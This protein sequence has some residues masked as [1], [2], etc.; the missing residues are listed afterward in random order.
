MHSKLVVLSGALFCAAGSF[1]NVV[2]T[3][4]NAE[5]LIAPDACPVVRFAADDLTNHLAMVFG[6]RV[7]IV[8]TPGEGKVQIVV[9]DSQWTRD[10]GLD[11]SVLPRD[12]FYICTQGGRIYIAGRDDPESR[13]GDEIRRGI[14]SRKERATAFGVCEFL[15][16]YAGVR[17]YFPDEYGT[18]VPNAG[19]LS[20]PEIKDTVKPQFTIR[21]CYISGAGPLPDVPIG[22]RQAPIKAMW[23]LR[24]RENTIDIPCCHGQNR[25]RI[26]ERFHAKHP[27]YFQLRKDG[28]RCTETNTPKRYMRGQLCHTSKVWDVFRRETIERMRKGEKYVDIMPQDGMSACRCANCMARYAQTND[29]SLA[30]GYCTELMWSNTVSVADAVRAAGL[31]GCVTQMAYGPCRNI[32][33]LNIPD[34]VK[35]VLAVGGPWAC[36]RPD[37]LDKQVAFVRNW[38]EKLNGKVSWIWTYPM[39]NYGRLQAHDVPQHAPRAYFEFYRRTAKYIDGSFVESNQES[40]T[41]FYNYL[42]YYVFA[43]LAWQPDLDIEAL[44]AEHNRLM[45]GAAASKMARFLDRLEEIWIGKVAIPSLIGETE[46][47][48]MIYAPSEEE[49]YDEIYTQE[50]LDEFEGYLAEAAKAVP[51]GSPEAMRVA[52]LRRR[53]FAPLAARRKTITMSIADELARRRNDPRPS[54]LDGLKWQVDK[55]RHSSFDAGESVTG[56]P[57][58]RI[59]S[60]NTVYLALPLHRIKDKLRPFGKYRL[61]YFVKTAG[62]EPVSGSKRGKGATIELEERGDGVKYRAVRYPGTRHW[63]GTKDWRCHA[64]DV[65]LGGDVCREGYRPTLWL[66]VFGAKGTVWFDGIR[67]ED[68]DSP[69][70]TPTPA[71]GSCPLQSPLL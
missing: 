38:S 14:Y 1:A 20:V 19:S 64:F 46:I 51:S 26:T 56:S 58:I 8:N 47:G 21:N 29:L 55:M 42:N 25:F 2:L 15:E 53:F 32:P 4:D 49:I 61:T 65:T 24:L 9:G 41:I 50:V 45:F 34:N 30:S 54:L 68:T 52:T 17:F 43:K 7:P 59:D 3:P 5:V 44:L 60:T 48:P 23:R 66:R 39:K 6:R 31:D 27:E 37:I 28:T 67:L 36:S 18:L 63:L 22:P 12:A 69:T 40:D 70:P 10:A 16:R 57:S 11:V 71:A 13:L 62:M 33:E 35:V